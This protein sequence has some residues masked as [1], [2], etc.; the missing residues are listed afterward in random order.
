MRNELISAISNDDAQ[1][2]WVC[3]SAPDG[4]LVSYDNDVDVS[5]GPAGCAI[6][7]IGCLGKADGE[8]SGTIGDV[9]PPPETGG[10][11]AGG[12]GAAGWL[13]ALAALAPRRRR[14]LELAA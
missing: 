12:A 10:C 7:S 8:G 13:V 11:S 3:S 5:A 1:H 14:R 4:L 6:V 2:G 9:P